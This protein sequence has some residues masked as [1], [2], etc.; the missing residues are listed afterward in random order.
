MDT[1]GMVLDDTERTPEESEMLFERTVRRMLNTPPKPQKEMK[2]GKRRG[3]R[4]EKGNRLAH[5]SKPEQP[6]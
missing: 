3:S 4:R 1:E 6:T 2:L 5:A